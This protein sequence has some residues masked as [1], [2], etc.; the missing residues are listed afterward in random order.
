MTQPKRARRLT[1][2][3]MLLGMSVLT[4]VF[5]ALWTTSGDVVTRTSRA[6]IEARIARAREA[7]A[8]SAT[9]HTVLV[10]DP[11]LVILETGNLINFRGLFGNHVQRSVY[12]WSE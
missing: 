4:N 1:V 7:H 6:E 2:L 11:R 9:W 10:D 5:Q 3:A 12:I 8:E